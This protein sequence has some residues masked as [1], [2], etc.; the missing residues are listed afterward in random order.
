MN[1]VVKKFINNI[2]HGNLFLVCSEREFL[3]IDPC[4]NFREIEPEVKGKRCAGIF[5]THAHFDHFQEIESF[6]PCNAPLFI[7][8][9]AVSKFSDPALN[10][11]GLFDDFKNY[12]VKH[13][14]LKF[15]GEG[16]QIQVGK[17]VG[18]VLELP[19]HS[20]CSIGLVIDGHFFCGDFI[21]AGR[22][23]GRYDLPTGSGQQLRQSLRRLKEL[24]PE[25]LVHPGHYEDFLLKDY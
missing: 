9:N 24:N 3:I 22:N 14:Q 6:L 1:L 7:H 15:V 8:K 18:T 12:D 23:I 2:R 11:S 20:D 4:V 17:S 10:C 5:L 19:G 13:Y 16:D 21:F 25:L